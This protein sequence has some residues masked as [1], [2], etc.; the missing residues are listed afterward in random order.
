MKLYPHA[1]LSRVE[2]AGFDGSLIGRAVFLF[3]DDGGSV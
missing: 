1:G 3:N 2:L